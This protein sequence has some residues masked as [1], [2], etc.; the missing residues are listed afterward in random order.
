MLKNKN[1]FTRCALDTGEKTDYSISMMNK[2]TE[3]QEYVLEIALRT[4]FRYGYKKTS[5]D[6]VAKAAGLTRQGL[7]FHYQ[8]KDELLRCAVEKAMNDGVR[9]VQLVLE[10]GNLP[11]SERLYRA[12]DAWFGGY[13]GL[14]S[15]EVIPDWEFHCHRVAGGRVEEDNAWFRQK[16]TEIL[17]PPGKETTPEI[18]TAAEMLFICGQRWKRTLQSRIEFEEKIKNAISLCCHA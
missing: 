7:Y 2:N 17:T 4:F 6:D 10:A 8:S 3:K 12:M 16:L 15:P 13:V 14:F 5:M 11:A 18:R 9:A 1:N